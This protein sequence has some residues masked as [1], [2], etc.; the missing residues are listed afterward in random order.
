MLVSVL[1][2]LGFALL[3][4]DERI[5]RYLRRGTLMLERSFEELMGDAKVVDERVGQLM[6]RHIATRMKTMDEPQRA[7]AICDFLA[8]LSEP[9]LAHFYSTLFESS[10]GSPFR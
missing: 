4:R 5:V 9:G 2:N 3:I 8:S 10:A 7:R 1:A 6:P